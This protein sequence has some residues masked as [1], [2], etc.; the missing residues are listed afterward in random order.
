MTTIHDFVWV[1][2]V[3]QSERC[4]RPGGMEDWLCYGIPFPFWVITDETSRGGFPAM[5]EASLHHNLKTGG[6]I[7][8]NFGYLLMFL[9]YNDNYPWFCMSKFRII[10]PLLQISW[11]FKLAWNFKNTPVM[12]WMPNEQKPWVQMMWN[13]SFFCRLTN[14]E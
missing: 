10:C 3:H 14:L 12:S 11:T 6:V 2:L 5:F 4:R 13:L 1:N 9:S 7:I 8:D